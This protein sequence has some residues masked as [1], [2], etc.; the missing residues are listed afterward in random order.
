MPGLLN[1]DEQ[2]RIADCLRTLDAAAG[3]DI[4]EP[5]TIHAVVRGCK[6]SA[7]ELPGR[8]L[9]EPVR[10][11][12]GIGL[13][14][15]EEIAAMKLV[16]VS[17]RSAKKDFFDLHALAEHG[18]AAEHMFTALEQM[19]PGEIDVD[20]G[21]H[22]TPRPDGFQRCGAGARPR[23]PQWCDVE[24]GQTLGCSPIRRSPVAPA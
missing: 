11:A 24:P 14:T 20:V 18:Y 6:V 8:W 2:V 17:T 1:R 4:S 12:E 13:A 9:A 22:I 21:A 7:F 23:D 3:I 16:A 19:Y 15:V 10:V 5:Q